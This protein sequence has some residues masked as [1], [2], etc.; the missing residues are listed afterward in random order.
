MRYILFLAGLVVLSA[1]ENPRFDQDKR[2][3]MAKDVLRRSIGRGRG[4]DITAFREDTLDSWTDT[5]VKRP[6]QYTLDFYYTDSA[7]TFHN[8]RGAVVFTPAGKSVIGKEISDLPPPA[9]KPIDDGHGN[10]D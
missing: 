5:L 4:F 10:K 6:I 7:G 9:N 8:K 3:I 2:Q 1:C